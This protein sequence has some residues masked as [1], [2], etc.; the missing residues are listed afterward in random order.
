MDTSVERRTMRKLT[1]RLVYFAA[2][3]FFFNYIDRVNIGFAALQMNQDLGFTATV[4]GFGAGVFFLSYALFEV[5]SN[6]ILHRVGPRLW[7]ARI[8]ITW[9]IISACFALITT[10]TTFYILRFLLGLAEA[11]FVPGIVL[12]FTYW[13]PEK[14]RGK[15]F[16]GFFGAA[17]LS[18]IIGA[19]LSGWILSSFSGVSGLSGWQWMFIIEGVPSVILGI[20]ILLILVD[21]PEDAKWLADDE[22]KW[23]LSRL[24]E[25]RKA[26]P[27]TAHGTVMDFLRDRRVLALTAIYFFYAVSVYGVTFW[28][29]LII[30]SF[31]GLSTIE[32]GFLTSIPYLCAFIF[33]QFV[34]Q[35]SDRTGER[36]WHVALCA[37]LGSAGLV[38]SALAGSPTMAFICL[39]IAAMGIW[40]QNGVFWTLPT[41][42]LKGTAAAGGIAFI[43][44]V[45]QFGGF[46]GPYAVG[47]VKDTTGSFT[48][49]LIILGCSSLMV[50]II[51]SNMRLNAGVR[52][53]GMPDRKLA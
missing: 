40:G 21:R 7:L 15:M 24:E 45:A 43:N 31:G 27:A 12:Y 49:P 36:K 10:E 8:M 18:S 6:L 51:A 50:T 5:P 30:K 33:M 32:I 23:L 37:L 19:P 53:A 9:G 41:S 22:R 34:A 2:V 48:V 4:Y 20:V 46:L 25:D 11:G 26:S 1:V 29:P 42:Y 39:C 3:L 47:W 44:S 35:N 17:L 13:I 16:A 14:Y 28:L 52:P 38:M